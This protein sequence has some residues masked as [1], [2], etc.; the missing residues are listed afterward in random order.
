LDFELSDDQVALRDGVVSLLQGRFDIATVRSMSDQPGAI[1]RAL[2][3]ELAETGVFSLAV[4]EAD[5]GLGLGWADTAIVFEQL[6]R[7]V[8]P[9]PLVANAVCA[10]LIEGVCE[11]STI[12]SLVEDNADNNAPIVIEHAAGID[13]VIALRPEGV[14]RIDPASIPL[15]Y[16]DIPLDALSPVGVCVSLPAGE[17]V[18][19]TDQA[20]RLGT[21]G[22]V[23]TSALQ[24]GLAAGATELAVAYASE[25]E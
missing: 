20:A 13:A 4:P 23:L 22:S 12:V 16:P 24:L 11:G 5:G 14:D 7:F 8:V 17:R 6:G 2:W 21:I 9:G 19:D 1:D 3:T 15:T 18:A 10:G 25:R